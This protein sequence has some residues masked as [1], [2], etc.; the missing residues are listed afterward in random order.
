[1]MVV[2]GDIEM[3]KLKLDGD[4]VWKIENSRQ[5]FLSCLKL[6]NTYKRIWIQE[7]V[8]LHH[9]LNRQKVNMHIFKKN[10]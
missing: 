4:K 2:N 5:I 1:M 3:V 10:K 9:R 8:H 6:R 7:F